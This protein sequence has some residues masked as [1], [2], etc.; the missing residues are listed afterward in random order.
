LTFHG[1]P[2]FHPLSVALIPSG[3]LDTSRSNGAPSG[4]VP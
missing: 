3:S 1:V 4:T 2:G